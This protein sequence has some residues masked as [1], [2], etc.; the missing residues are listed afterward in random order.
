[1]EPT[2]T[3]TNSAAWRIWH[4]TNYTIG[5]I[6]FL[7][8]SLLLFPYFATILTLQLSSSI[9]AYLYTFGSFT[10]ALADFT[11]WTHYESRICGN[12]NSS[13]CLHKG[14]SVN[15]FTNFI[16]SSIYLVGSAMFL[17]QI[18]MTNEGLICFIVASAIIVGAQT[19]KI[20]R[21]VR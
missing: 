21:G 16:G 13:W 2:S 17:P 11:E 12:R 1:M 8:G 15:F 10:F 7:F 3:V 14:Y 19:W 9:S 4:A 20:V 5:A 6:T 18:N